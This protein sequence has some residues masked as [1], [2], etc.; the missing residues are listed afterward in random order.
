MIWGTIKLGVFLT[1]AVGCG[2]LFATVPVGGETLAHRVQTLWAR[3]AVRHQVGVLETRVRR[4]VEAATS[5][6]RPGDPGADAI[7]PHG[8]AVDPHAVAK[9][10]SGGPVGDHFRASE[11]QAVQHIISERARR[12]THRPTR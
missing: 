1:V 8:D 4:G 6:P 11:R 5:D 12:A 7:A 3:P 2:M 10:V 9:V